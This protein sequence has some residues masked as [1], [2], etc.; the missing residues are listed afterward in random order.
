M[1]A[2]AAWASVKRDAYR[3]P[4]QA[5]VLCI[6]IQCSV[7]SHEE[8]PLSRVP[9][10]TESGR[11]LISQHVQ[12]RDLPPKVDRPIVSHRRVIVLCFDEDDRDAPWITAS[13]GDPA[14]DIVGFHLRQIPVWPRRHLQ[15]I[16]LTIAGVRPKFVNTSAICLLGEIP[17]TLRPSLRSISNS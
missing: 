5:A 7:W 11:S 10:T 3:W 8:L 14:W 15:L 9:F 12:V 2:R 17:P 6:V 13:D 16:P 4:R 1:R